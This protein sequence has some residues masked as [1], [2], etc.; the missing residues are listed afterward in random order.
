MQCASSMTSIEMRAAIPART[1]VRNRSLAKRSGEINRMSTSP[2]ASLDSTSLHSLTL[3]ELIVSAR[4]PIRSAAAIWLRIS[5]RS[6]DIS[7][8]GPLPPSRNS[9][10]AMK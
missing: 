3:S 7:S 4:T 2:R 5:A 8:A 9:F 6:G 10:V 1:C